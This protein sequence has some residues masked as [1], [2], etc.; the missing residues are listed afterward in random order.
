MGNRM[1][2]QWKSL[3]LLV[4]AALIWGAAFSAQSIAGEHV[5]AFTFNATRFYIGTLTLL[6][7]IAVADRRRRVAGGGSVQNRRALWVGGVLCGVA[8]FLASYLQQRGIEQ[9]TAGKSGFITALYIVLVPLVA[10]VFQKKRAGLA[11]WV[12]VALALAGMYL[13]CIRD[14]FSVSEGDWY[15]LACAL[16]F[17][18]Q[19]LIVERYSPEADCIR[20]SC[21]QFLVAGILGTI[22]MLTIERPAFSDILAA[23]QPIAFVGVFSCG[24]A[25]TCQMLGQRRVAAPIASL[26]MSMES[27]FAAVFGALLLG[28]TMTG[29]EIAGSVLMFLAILLVQLWRPGRRQRGLEPASSDR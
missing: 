18:V 6:P 16:C 28:E 1:G 19:I 23:W 17:A 21:I 26:I 27:V 9:T 5:G 2:Q 13:L 24:V 11:V 29:R 25:Y 14:G 15:L 20:M 3:L 7:V 10:L 4:L 22:P 8:L 12:G